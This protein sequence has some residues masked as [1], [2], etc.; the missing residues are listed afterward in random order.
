MPPQL[1]QHAGLL[2]LRLIPT[3][4]SC[5]ALPICHPAKLKA[6]NGGTTK[7]P[8]SIRLCGLVAACWLIV[9]TTRCA[10]SGAFSG[11]VVSHVSA[12]PS[13]GTAEQEVARPLPRLSM[14]RQSS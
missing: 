7:D 12:V 8:A 4:E 13:S 11:R 1:T 6:D 9:I 5:V 10:G 14:L 3:S 2:V